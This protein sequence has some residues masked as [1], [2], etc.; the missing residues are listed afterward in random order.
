VR[1]EEDTLGV[2]G[3]WYVDRGAWWREM[4]VWK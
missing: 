3:P 1:R 2:H 4:G